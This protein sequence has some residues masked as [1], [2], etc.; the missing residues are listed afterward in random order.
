MDRGR[1]RGAEANDVVDGDDAL[2]GGQRE[3]PELELVA[4]A[5]RRGRDVLPGEGEEL[6]RGRGDAGALDGRRDDGRVVARG[7]GHDAGLSGGRAADAAEGKHLDAELVGALGQDAA[8]GE[9][10]RLVDA[11][12]AEVAGREV[13]GQIGGREREREPR[14]EREEGRA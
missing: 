6:G 13:G 7:E 3:V 12:E 10:V 11:G 2:P 5:R 4:D 8:V 14:L 1:E 9:E